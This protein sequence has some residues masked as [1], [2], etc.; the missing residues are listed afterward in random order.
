[1][2]IAKITAG[3]GYTYLTRHIARGDAEPSRR[4]GTRPPTT[5]RR[6]TRRDG[7][8]GGARRC[9]GWPGGRS[10]R[11]RCVALFGLGEHPD[12]DAIS[13]RLPRRARARRDD[14]PAA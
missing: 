13:H 12:G 4:R 8:P 2:T 11:S 3:D 9:S 10:P 14:R 7:G 1:M 5:R 6:G